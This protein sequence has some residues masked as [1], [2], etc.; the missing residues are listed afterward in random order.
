MSLIKN[1]I[2]EKPHYFLLFQSH[3]RYQNYLLPHQNHQKCD[4]ILKLPVKTSFEGSKIFKTPKLKKKSV[5]LI[6]S[7]SV[8]VKGCKIAR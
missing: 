3:F 1:L 6:T 8:I 2:Q 4:L 5:K 7:N